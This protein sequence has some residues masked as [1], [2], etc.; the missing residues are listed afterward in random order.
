MEP[1]AEPKRIR[2]VKDFVDFEVGMAY[3]SGT[4]LERSAH[5]SQYQLPGT[6]LGQQCVSSLSRLQGLY[7]VLE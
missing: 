5:S 3:R 1:S 2:L 6:R 4:I 7:E